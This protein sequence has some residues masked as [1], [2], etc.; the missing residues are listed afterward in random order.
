MGVLPRSRV[1]GSVYIFAGF[2]KQLTALKAARDQIHFWF[3][4]CPVYLKKEK[5][6]PITLLPTSRW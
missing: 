2:R 6:K 4:N 5:A 1:T 3:N